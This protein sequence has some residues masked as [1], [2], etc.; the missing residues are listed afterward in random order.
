MAVQAISLVC[1]VFLDIAVLA[2]VAVTPDV[3]ALQLGWLVSDGEGARWPYWSVGQGV[4]VIVMAI[5]LI[6][7]ES[8]EAGTLSIASDDGTQRW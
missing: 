7:G 8:N 4:W 1:L 3:V 2:L 6:V 5:I